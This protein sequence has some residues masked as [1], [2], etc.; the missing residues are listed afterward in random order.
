MT[1]FRGAHVLITGA[2]CGLGRL[3][4]LEAVRRGGR[5]TLLDRDASGLDRVCEEIRALAGEAAAFVVDIADKVALQATCRDV[6]A[7][8]GG[9]DILI[10][11]AGIVTG[12]LLLECSDDDIERTFQVNA[13]AGFW[14][15]RAFLPGMLAVGRGHIVTVASAAGLAGTSR[16]VDYC[17][18]KFAAVGFDEALRLELKRLGSPIQTTL[19]CPYFIDTG[20]FEGARTRFAWL[21][22]ILDADRVV[23]RILGAVEGNRARLVM[24]RF[25]LSVLL[26]RLLPPTVFDAL[27]GFFGVNRSMDA[28]VGRH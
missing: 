2:A 26:A 12:K 4:A 17:A 25:V 19:V 14:T 22:P 18:S 13:L 3:L 5:V 16:L 6:L 8:R 28:F 15:V 21:L 9:V 11:N 20:M 1:G 23:Q 24:P 7:T 10:N 27:L